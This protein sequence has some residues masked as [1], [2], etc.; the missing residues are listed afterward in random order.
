MY[1]DFNYW[2]IVPFDCYFPGASVFLISKFR[3]SQYCVSIST[4]LSAQ[5]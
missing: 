2:W 1:N 5:A 4:S 3:R